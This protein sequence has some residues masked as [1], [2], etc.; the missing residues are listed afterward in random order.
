MHNATTYTPPRGMTRT[1]DPRPAL[2]RAWKANRPLTL[3]GLAMIATFLVSLVGLA[4]DPRVIIG[5]PAWLKPMKFAISISIF[6]FTLVWMLG[7]VQGWPRL[8]R[9]ISLVTTVALFGEIVI[10]VVQVP[11][12][13]IGHGTGKTTLQ[14]L[15]GVR[16][17]ERCITRLDEPRQ[18]ILRPTIHIRWRRDRFEDRRQPVLDRHVIEDMPQLLNHAPRQGMLDVDDELHP[19]ASAVAVTRAHVRIHR[20]HLA[21]K[22]NQRFERRI[23]WLVGNPWGFEY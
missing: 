1:L 21:K 15:G 3:L 7:L 10:I 4:L 12:L 13:D 5:A 9:L 14:P 18:K 20:R 19:P 11:F 23:V 2:R 6:S 22:G 17:G 8:A 16:W